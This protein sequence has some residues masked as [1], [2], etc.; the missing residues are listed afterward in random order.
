MMGLPMDLQSDDLAALQPQL[1]R[2]LSLL[3]KTREDL[4]AIRKWMNEEFVDWL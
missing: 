1:L 2:N 4:N 3:V